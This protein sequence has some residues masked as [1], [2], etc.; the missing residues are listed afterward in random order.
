MNIDLYKKKYKR[1]RQQYVIDVSFQY[2][3]LFYFFLFLIKGKKVR[4]RDEEG[5]EE[6]KR[7]GDGM[8]KQ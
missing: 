5:G 7:R 8:R 2:F 4:R 6:K 3:S 1:Q